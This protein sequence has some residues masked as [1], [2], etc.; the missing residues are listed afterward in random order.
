MVSKKKSI[1]N[2]IVWEWLFN[3][4]GR[5]VC[6]FSSK[7]NLFLP[8]FI[9]EKLIDPKYKN[10]IYIFCHLQFSM[11][12]FGNI[13]KNTDLLYRETNSSLAKNIVSLIFCLSLNIINFTDPSSMYALYQK[14]NP[15]Q[16]MSFF[17]NFLKN[18]KLL[19]PKILMFP[20]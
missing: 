2:F 16:H 19:W 7:N 10:K 6:F 12:N 17:C 15:M 5:G 1:V 9:G 4:Y 3:C 18:R 8:N 11:I 14:H 20:S 13:K